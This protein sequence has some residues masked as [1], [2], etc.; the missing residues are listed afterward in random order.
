MVY[1]YHIRGPPARKLQRMSLD[2]KRGAAFRCS[3]SH[4]VGPWQSGRMQPTYNR[5]DVLAHVRGVRIPPAPPLWYHPRMK[6][7]KQ[8]FDAL[9]SKVLRAKPVPRK[10]IKTAKRHTPTPILKKP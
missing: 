6:V 1:L 9:L 10:K 3:P 7:E 2:S 8:K 4:N 5:S